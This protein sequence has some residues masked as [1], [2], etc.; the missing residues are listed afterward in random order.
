MEMQHTHAYASATTH[1]QAQ[2]SDDIAAFE[3]EPCRS[4]R[5]GMAWHGMARVAGVYKPR[6]IFG[7]GGWLFRQAAKQNSANGM[8]RHIPVCRVGYA[9]VCVCMCMCVVRFKYNT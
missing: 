1:A 2:G 4:C 7:K 3:S 8:I 9:R 6:S 5:H